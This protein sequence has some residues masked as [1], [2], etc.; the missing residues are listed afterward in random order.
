[1]YFDQCEP[2]AFGDIFIS[3]LGTST[4]GQHR[5]RSRRSSRAAT[6]FV[7]HRRSNESCH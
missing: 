3:G 4:L 7:A 6:S 1:M 2:S 5:T